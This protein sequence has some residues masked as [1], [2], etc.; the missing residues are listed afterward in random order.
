MGKPLSDAYPVI[1]YPEDKKEFGKTRVY[2]FGVVG[3]S[4]IQL[5][6]DQNDIIRDGRW[7]GT[8]LGLEEP[9]KAMYGYYLR[10]LPKSSTQ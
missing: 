2:Y 9:S 6:T 7:D 8:I 3:I 10:T 5:V 1:G 4:R